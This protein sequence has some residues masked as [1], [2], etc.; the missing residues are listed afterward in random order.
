MDAI[1]LGYRLLLLALTLVSLQTQATVLFVVPN[2]APKIMLMINATNQQVLEDVDIRLLSEVKS[3]EA[4]TYEAIVLVGAQVLSQWQPLELPTVAVLVSREQVEAAKISLASAIYAE[5]SLQQQLA[6]ARAITNKQEKLGL[7]LQH[8]E[9]LAHYAIDAK[10]LDKDLV[11]ASVAEHGSLNAALRAILSKSAALVGVYDQQLYSSDNIKNILITAYRNNQA[12][13]GPSQAYLRA[14]SIASVY[15]G[16][17][18]VAKRL[19]E[20]LKQGLQQGEWP[21]ADY[22][23]YFKVGVNQQVARSLNFDLA[24]EKTL[25]KQVHALQAL[26][27]AKQNAD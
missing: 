14:G 6:L 1:R 24:D 12:L 9:D 22:S 25:A 5:P 2:Y 27:S 11:V 13:I 19:G 16:G 26:D 7:L 10:E 18:E 20:I 15:S 17:E 8:Q 4:N 3:I 21:A 23:P